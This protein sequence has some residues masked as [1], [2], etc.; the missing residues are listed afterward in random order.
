[1]NTSPTRRPDTNRFQWGLPGSSR[2]VCLERTFERSRGSNLGSKTRVKD[3]SAHRHLWRYS[4]FERNI[5]VLPNV[6]P[7]H[8]SIQKS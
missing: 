8:H 5:S 7:L 2:L 3:R 4:S 1:M 6:L